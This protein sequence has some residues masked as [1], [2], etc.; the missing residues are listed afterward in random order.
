MCRV[1]MKTE[2]ISKLSKVFGRIKAEDWEDLRTKALASRGLAGSPK[3]IPKHSHIVEEEEGT[4][5]D[6]DSFENI[7]FD[8]NQSTAN[9]QIQKWSLNKNRTVRTQSDR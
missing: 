2:K 4:S 8:Q 5:S 1:I 3:Y 7:F 9:S 6:D